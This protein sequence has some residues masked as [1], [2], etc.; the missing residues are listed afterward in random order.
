LRAASTPMDMSASM[1]ATAW[2]SEMAL[3]MVLRSVVKLG[4]CEFT[5]F[6]HR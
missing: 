4:Y 5:F 2:C 3:P 1:K 6:K